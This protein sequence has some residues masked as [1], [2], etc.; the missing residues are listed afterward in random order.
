MNTFLTIF[1][2]LGKALYHPLAWS[3]LFIIAI[4]YIITELGFSYWFYLL[5]IPASFAGYFLN[6]LVRLIVEVWNG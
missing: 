6:K 1:K 5:V 2:I 3:M 4:S